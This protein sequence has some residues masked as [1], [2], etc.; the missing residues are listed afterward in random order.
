MQGT[1]RESAISSR[2]DAKWAARCLPTGSMRV[3]SPPTAPPVIGWKE[4]LDLPELG[5]HHIKAKVD[6]GA[7]SSALHVERITVLEER[8]DGSAELLLCLAPDR[9]HPDRVQNIRV[10]QIARIPVTDSGGHREIRPL[11][12]TTLVLGPVVKRIRL[13]LTDR[14]S[15]LFRMILGRKALEGTFIVDVGCKYLFGRP[16]RRSPRARE[17]LSPSGS[18]P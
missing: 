10:H 4:Y 6:T 12:E 5:I 8:P 3:V 7:R 11:I 1:T 15:M 13:T 9:R 18:P 2:V 16:R 17:P 14:S